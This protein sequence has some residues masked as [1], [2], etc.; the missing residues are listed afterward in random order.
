MTPLDL[1]LYL[2][3]VVEETRSLHKRRAEVSSGWIS[4]EGPFLSRNPTLLMFESLDKTIWWVFSLFH[5]LTRPFSPLL[6]AL[7]L[8]PELSRWMKT[9]CNLLPIHSGFSQHSSTMA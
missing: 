5:G 1:G 4:A 9:R 6:L 8:L 7:L 2:H 3:E